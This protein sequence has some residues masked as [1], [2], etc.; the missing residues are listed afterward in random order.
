MRL[1]KRRVGMLSCTWHLITC[2]FKSHSD[3]MLESQVLLAAGLVVM[4]DVRFASHL[5]IGL[6]RDDIIMK[7]R[8]ILNSFVLKEEAGTDLILTVPV[9][10]KKILLAT[11][12]TSS[13]I[14]SIS[15]GAALS[16]V[17]IRNITMSH[18]S[19]QL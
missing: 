3:Y 9:I 18:L 13:G 8:K 11:S 4:R 19:E 17:F 15:T 14:S 7:S 12:N 2:G 5:Q 10:K 16:N 6:D 1:G